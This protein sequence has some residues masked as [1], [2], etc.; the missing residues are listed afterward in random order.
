M[1]SGLAGAI[2]WW[3]HPIPRLSSWYMSAAMAVQLPR[4]LGWPFLQPGWVLSPCLSVCFK[5]QRA[6]G[7][8][9]LTHPMLALQSSKYIDCSLFK[10]ISYRPELLHP[11]QALQEWCHMHQHWSGQL[12]LF[13]PTWVH[14][15]QLWDW[16]QWM[17]CQPLQEWRKLHCKFELLVPSETPRE[18]LMSVLLIFQNCFLDF[19]AAL[20]KYF[21]RFGFLSPQD[22]ENSYSCT[23]PPGFYGKNCELSAMTCADGP[24]FN[25]GRCT[26]NPDGGYSCRCPLGYSGFNCEKKIDYCSSSPCANGKAKHAMVTF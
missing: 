12:H 24:C 14:R 26:D 23:C 21:E 20:D 19:K 18:E 2:L 1:Q 4:R 13:L 8:F 11:P 22:L 6:S 10:K 25:G 15:L 17:W 7:Y 16:N 3:V 5:M 9:Q